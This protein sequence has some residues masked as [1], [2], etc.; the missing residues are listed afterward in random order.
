MKT[1]SRVERNDLTSSSLSYAKEIP[2]GFRPR[3]A[4][5]NAEQELSK[6][7]PK[8]TAACLRFDA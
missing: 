1:I 5:A 7:L 3:S 8:T 6:T 2:L 4:V